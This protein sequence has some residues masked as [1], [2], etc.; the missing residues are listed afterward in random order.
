MHY[1]SLIRFDFI[2]LPIRCIVNL[3]AILR[4]KV[5]QVSYDAVLIL[6]AAVTSIILPR[7][8]CK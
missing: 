7:F 5:L 2:K 4:R 8:Q 3:A 6:K 1:V